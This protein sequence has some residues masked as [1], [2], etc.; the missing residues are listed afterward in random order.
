M[1]EPKAPAGA[2]PRRGRLVRWLMWGLAGLFVL[3]VG[4]QAYL[5]TV[6]RR[7]VVFVDGP[8]ALRAGEATIATGPRTLIV[9]AHPDDVE[10]YMGG[11]VARLVD[12]GA[13]ITI[14]MATSGEARQGGLR[15]CTG[16]RAPG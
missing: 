2:S 15:G 11:T 6:G 13:Q 3:L 16:G 8:G 14:V 4:L 10:W 7:P 9:A 12:A 5:D 1:H